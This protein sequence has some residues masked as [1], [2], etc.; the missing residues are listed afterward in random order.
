ML[1]DSLIFQLFILAPLK[2]K[3]N[4]N[5]D[6]PKK[7]RSAKCQSMTLLALIFKSSMYVIKIVKNKNLKTKIVVPFIYSSFTLISTL[8]FHFQQLHFK[9]KILSRIANIYDGY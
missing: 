1:E 5:L 4:E 7:E 9:N 2:G 8:I 6:A 3:K